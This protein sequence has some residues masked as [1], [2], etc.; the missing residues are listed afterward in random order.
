MYYNDWYFKNDCFLSCKMIFCEKN[1]E[2]RPDQYPQNSF[3]CI[4]LQLRL[5]VLLKEERLATNGYEI[6]CWKWIYIYFI[7]WYWKSLN[8]KIGMLFESNENYKILNHCFVVQI[9]YTNV[10][11][12]SQRLCGITWWKMY[13]FLF[14]LFLAPSWV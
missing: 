13:S 8:S 12:G 1:K 2:K 7:N 11:Q 14:H 5:E 9:L 10:V 4:D 6:R 3:D